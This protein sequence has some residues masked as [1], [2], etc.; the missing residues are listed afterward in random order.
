M[1]RSY[2]CWSTQY[3]EGA[4]ALI[5]FCRL[6]DI[7]FSTPQSQ[8]NR[9]YKSVSASSSASAY[10]PPLESSTHSGASSPYLIS[11]NY[12]VST[13]L[14]SDIRRPCIDDER[15]P[16]PRVRRTGAAII[17]F[18]TPDRPRYTGGFLAIPGLGGAPG[19]RLRPASWDS[20]SRVDGTLESPRLTR[21]RSSD[22][23]RGDSGDEDLPFGR[24]TLPPLPVPSDSWRSDFHTTPTASSTPSRDLSPDSGNL[25]A[26][27]SVLSTSFHTSYS[28]GGYR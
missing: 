28:D 12:E 25:S 27:N 10:L 21:S 20:P 2:R 13:R 26:T 22:D 15:G 4:A 18:N 14:S 16:T 5:S 7:P 23:F 11:N 9:D 19:P 3:P 24:R 1:S 6:F 17:P 8:S